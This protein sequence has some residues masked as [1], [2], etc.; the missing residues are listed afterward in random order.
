MTSDRGRAR[1]V[2]WLTTLV[3]AAI[4][5]GVALTVDFP[6][7][8]GGIQSDE[9]TYYL[10]GHSL[11]ADGDLEY[12][13]EDLQRTYRDFPTGP[14]GIFLKRGTEPTGVSLSA[15][16]PFVTISGRPDPDR[17][18]LYFG[19]SFLYPLLASPLVW[20]FGT[21]GFV[22]FNA[23]LLAAAFL[24]AGIFISA[25]SGA[26]TGVLLASAFVFATV[27]PVYFAWIAP[28]LFNFSLGLIAYVL[29]LYKYAV[30][31]DGEEAPPSRLRR[32]WTDTAAGALVGLLTFSKVTNVLLLVPMVAWLAFRGLWRR[33]AGAAVA[34]ALVTAL[35]FGANVAITG[36]WNYQGGDRA[37]CYGPYPLER[38]GAGL[39]VCAER[40]RD[41][42]LGSVIFDREVFW[43]NLR[44]NLAYVVVGRNSGLL[45]YFFP[46]LFALGAV[47]LTRRRES[48]Q[49]FIL[50]GV[51]AHLVLFVISQ[52]YSW[53]GGGGSVGNRYFM[54][55]YGMCLFLLPPIRSAALALVPWAVG[56]LF[57]AK[58]VLDPF[59]T[60]IR[61]G[62]HAKS[63]LFRYLPVELTNT[64]DLP[65]NTDASRVRLWYGDT[66]EGNPGFQIYY[67]DD[68]AYLPEADG[69]SFWIRGESTAQLLI[70][71]VEPEHRMELQLSAGAAATTTEIR[72][73]GRAETIDLAAG[74]TTR[75][76][77]EVDPGLPFKRDRADPAWVWVMSV[78]SSAGFVPALE[79]G[80]ADVR[81]LGVRVRPIF[82]D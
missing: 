67:L 2:V 47:L 75:V 55:A 74:Q 28:E 29:W 63:G 32:G 38:P 78:S 62:D 69:L 11:V 50:A 58:L 45:P 24:A 21:N 26:T 1:R 41:E 46:G 15:A 61:P 35:F 36:E 40:A 4:Y 31:E 70:K 14:S 44:A 10:M 80:S 65:L 54:G 77:I 52:P 7:A 16:P 30:P 82:V 71:T 76:Q 51:A 8:A 72:W 12:R 81:Y 9:A 6:A 64:N 25:R 59:Q 68:N 73:N 20:L 66:G 17:R 5:G 19:K 43:S 18:R 23:L 60:S 33:A 37:T 48:W 56:A 39:E 79:E 22:V 13:H 42:A 3:V 57:M 27:V 34:W 49:W 53:F